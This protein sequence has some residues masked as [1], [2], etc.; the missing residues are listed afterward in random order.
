[1]IGTRIRIGHWYVPNVYKYSEKIEFDNF[2]G[3][4]NT[5]K[6]YDLTDAENRSIGFPF[7]YATN[8]NELAKGC[9]AFNSCSGHGACDYCYQK[10]Y[11]T[12]GYG[13]PN[14]ILPTGW[15]TDFSCSKS[16]I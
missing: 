4:Y 11:C 15:T 6:S 3:F 14:D 16:N 7:R 13:G 8:L 5:G 12:D 2:P 9:D 1:M 10:C